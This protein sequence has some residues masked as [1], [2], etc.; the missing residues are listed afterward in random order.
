MVEKFGH[1]VTNTS[2]NVIT[3][4]KLLAGSAIQLLKQL[5][6]RYLRCECRHVQKFV[7][8]DD[9]KL[10]RDVLGGGVVDHRG[11]FVE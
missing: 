7:I 9:V 1:P 3:V 4:H 10:W 8:K 6:A 11:T 5:V 2:F